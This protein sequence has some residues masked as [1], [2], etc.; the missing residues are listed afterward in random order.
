MVQILINCLGGKY[1][2]FLFSHREIVKSVFND[3]V[4]KGKFDDKLCLYL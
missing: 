2:C 4:N 1:I 3:T